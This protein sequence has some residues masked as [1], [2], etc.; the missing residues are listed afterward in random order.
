MIQSR[1][2]KLETCVPQELFSS[3]CGFAWKCQESAS[4]GCVRQGVA[5][6]QGCRP[7]S[8]KAGTTPTDSSAPNVCAFSFEKCQFLL[9]R[10]SHFI[11]LLAFATSFPWGRVKP[12][13]AVW[14]VC[15]ALQWKDRIS[16]APPWGHAGADSS[17]GPLACR[18]SL[19]ALY[20]M[21]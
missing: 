18:N 14:K 11:H 4:W 3:R 20:L 8:C 1:K 21:L 6:G 7:T 10:G 13:T 9:F 2:E 12:F 15:V 16:R 19:Q 17:S 5:G